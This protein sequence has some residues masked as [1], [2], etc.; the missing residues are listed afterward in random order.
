MNSAISFLRL[1]ARGGWLL[2]A[3]SMVVVFFMITFPYDQLQARLLADV[4]RRTGLEIMAEGW[5]L[6]W[7]VG[8][9]WNG[10]SLIAPGWPRLGADRVQ[11]TVEPLSLLKGRPILE[12]TAKLS[13]GPDGQGGLIK[14]RLALDSWS[15]GGPAHVNGSIERLALAGLAVPMVRQ[16]TMQAEFDQRWRDPSSAVGILG[17]EGTWQVEAEGLV[18]EQVPM[19]PLLLPSLTASR[20]KG[21]LKCKDGA[22]RIETLQ[23]EGPDGTISGEGML[24]LKAPLS[25]SALM[26]SLS[27]TIAEA[28][29]QRFPAAGL[30]P[31]SPGT[32]LKVTLTGPLS[33]LQIT[34]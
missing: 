29:K 26:L 32:P 10:V 20:L 21:R 11:V 19:G 16:G 5:Q 30:V 23:G 17:G 1:G 9:V 4:S 28:L 27:V 31:V 8:F 15:F 18:L 22:C 25:E 13:S 2:Y 12:G 14:G 6:A 33:R 34:M 7:P 3:A 24:T